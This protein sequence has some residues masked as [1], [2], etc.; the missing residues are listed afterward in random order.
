MQ[1]KMTA[2][3]CKVVARDPSI[4]E[5]VI[6]AEQITRWLLGASE[7]GEGWPIFFGKFVE[8]LLT[9]DNGA[10]AEIIGPGRPTGPMTGMPVGVAHL[11]SARCQRTGD[12]E[13]PILYHDRSGKIYKLHYTR[14]MTLILA[15]KIAT[16][17]IT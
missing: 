11:D 15:I 6:Q 17:C 13:F 12:Q 1:S 3:P 5:H 14:V 4:R 10:F 9:Q 8:D 2:I 7:F 16:A